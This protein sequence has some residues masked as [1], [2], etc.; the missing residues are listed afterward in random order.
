MF[1]YSKRIC[2]KWIYVGSLVN[3]HTSWKLH[4]LTVWGNIFNL[5]L[6]MLT[7]HLCPPLFLQIFAS[8]VWN[9]QNKHINLLECTIPPPSPPLSSLQKQIWGF[10]LVESFSKLSKAKK[11]NRQMFFL[12]CMWWWCL[13]CPIPETTLDLHRDFWWSHWQLYGFYDNSDDDCDDDYIR[14]VPC[15]LRMSGS[16]V[17]IMFNIAWAAWNKENCWLCGTILGHD[18]VKSSCQI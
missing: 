1:K 6:A 16:L 4:C 9:I 17:V 13:L 3:T 15:L 2:L 14:S 8:I 12:G 7:A 10:S 11:Q 5:F 18:D